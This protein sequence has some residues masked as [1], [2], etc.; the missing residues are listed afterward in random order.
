M[1]NLAYTHTQAQT[2]GGIAKG[3]VLSNGSIGRCLSQ[4]VSMVTV[5][6]IREAV[7]LSVMEM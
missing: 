6:V 5:C 3:T 1:A 7:C 2:E 4:L